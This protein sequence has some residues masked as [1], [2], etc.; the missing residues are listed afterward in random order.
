ME[1]L[2]QMKLAGQ[3]DSTTVTFLQGL[4]HDEFQAET[5]QGYVYRKPLDYAGDFRLIRPPFV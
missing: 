4:F 3:L 1:N 5:I 2:Y